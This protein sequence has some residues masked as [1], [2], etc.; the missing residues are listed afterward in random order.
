MLLTDIN[1]NGVQCTL[2][3]CVMGFGFLISALQLSKQRHYEGS[4]SFLEVVNPSYRENLLKLKNLAL[5]MFLQDTMV[6]P[7]ESEV[8]LF[9]FHILK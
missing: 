3:T 4:F 7:K 6:D 5:V 2:L 1:I 8:S 9:F